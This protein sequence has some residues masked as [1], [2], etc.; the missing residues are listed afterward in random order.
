VRRPVSCFLT[1]CPVPIKRK[2]PCQT[3][4]NGTQVSAQLTFDPGLGNLSTGTNCLATGA[5]VLDVPGLILTGSGI[6]IA[7]HRGAKD[8]RTEISVFVPVVWL[9]GLVVRRR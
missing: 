4:D 9:K 1:C 5:Q 3:G 6:V 8:A 2:L 7:H